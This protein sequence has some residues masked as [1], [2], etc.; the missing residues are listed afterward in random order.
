MASPFDVLYVISPHDADRQIF[1]FL[2][3]GP[4]RLPHATR[5]LVARYPAV[6]GDGRDV[7]V[8]CEAWPARFYTVHALESTDHEGEP[9]PAFSIALGSGR[10]QLAADIA[11]AIA[12]GM[13]TP[14]TREEG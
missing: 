11:T 14:T 10:A 3:C 7:E 4:E 12:N 13:L 2:W 8:E 9:K 6:P 1:G 5:V